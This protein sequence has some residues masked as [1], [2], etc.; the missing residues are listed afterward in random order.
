MSSKQKREYFVICLE[1]GVFYA[2]GARW[3]R[4]LR[5]ALHLRTR[6]Y[7]EKV[8]AEGCFVVRVVDGVIAPECG[9]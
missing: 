4:D 8:M 9:T 3:V 1:G 6:E 7:A 2:V 5:E